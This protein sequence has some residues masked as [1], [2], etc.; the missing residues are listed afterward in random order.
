MIPIISIA[1]TLV[2]GL[3]AIARN[4]IHI[5]DLEQQL[6]KLNAEKPKPTCPSTGSSNPGCPRRDK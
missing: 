4:Q 2:I 3:P 5:A 1:L 6:T